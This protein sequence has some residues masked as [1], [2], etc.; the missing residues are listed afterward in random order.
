MAADNLGVDHMTPV[1]IIGMSCRFPGA[2][3]PDR[4]WRN[5]ITGTS[6]VGVVPDGRWA[7]PLTSSLA[8]TGASIRFGGF[9]DDV[10]LFDAD[11]FGISRREAQ[12]MDPQQRILLELAWE[13]I[14]DAA[15]RA[16]D[17]RGAR[18]GVFIGAC[19]DDFRFRYLITGNLDRFGH[20]GTNR[21]MLANRLS[22]HF[23]LRGPSEVI[24]SGQSSSLTALHRAL[25]SLRLGECEAA[26]V[27]G[28]NLNLLQ[29]VNEQVR[30]WGG[31][32]PDGRCYTFDD[33]ANGYVR[34]EG[35]GCVVLKPFDAA[36]R[37]G[38][39][40]YCVIRGS[41]T[42]N[43]G[44]RSGLGVP[45]Q[46][47]QCDV[48]KAAQAVAGVSAADVAYIELH[49]TGT[50]V[51]D[52]IEAGAVGEIVGLARP[53]EH[54]VRV[55][56]VKT[57]IGHL[58]S[59]AGIAGLLKACLMLHYGQVPPSLNFVNRNPGIALDELNIRL[60]TEVEE[61]A[62]TPQDVV[63]VSSFGMGGTNVH[64]ILGPSPKPAE[65]NDAVYGD[66]I[67]C[68]SGRSREALRE[69]AQVLLRYLVGLGTSPSI[70]DV[71]WTLS[72][73]TQ[74]AHRAAVVGSDWPEIRHGL[75]KVVCGNDLAVP[76][77]WLTEAALE[78][79]RF[80]QVAS[81]YIRTGDAAGVMKL[82]VKNSRK[83][84]LLPTYPFQRDVFDI[85]RVTG[86]PPGA[87]STP[88][89]S[90]QDPPI[91]SFTEQWLNTY[92][93]ADRIWTVRTLLERELTVVLGGSAPDLDH[94]LSFTDI[95][96]D[97]M[98]LLEFLD[99]INNVTGIDLPE[100]VLFDH[101]T[102]SELAECVKK[103]M[104]LKHG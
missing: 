90:P 1:A 19:A 4:F 77:G 21:C 59:A 30:L 69:T 25:S 34:G 102:I 8:A 75:E 18:W 42:T 80:M 44:G 57:N 17:V 40:I 37:D 7:D 63:G 76:D 70:T 2:E 85:P 94:E 22:H 61:G 28:I 101:P 45:S 31:L 51:G 33:R 78:R 9:V 52:P 54:P 91:A 15:V 60:V 13:S 93:D 98:T 53:Y 14:E 27:G 26:V 5:L 82:I 92:A 99:R 96:I 103:E 87:A 43:D 12:H 46:E 16:E 20:T 95:G 86:G 39:H 84:S 58:E 23:G 97:S 11:F 29:E 62:F 100:T 55:G 67:W 79:G 68:L 49:G 48:M 32:S 73:R 47:A 72:N 88:Q 41:A 3:N 24:D 104:E 74:W 65:E 83:V 71:A 56:S 36:V 35:G 38:D 64:V 81:E 6:S 50:P 89:A 66:T 10:E